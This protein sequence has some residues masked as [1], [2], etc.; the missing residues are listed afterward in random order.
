SPGVVGVDVE[1]RIAFETRR[2]Q[3]VARNSRNQDASTLSALLATNGVLDA[4][5]WSN[6]TAAT[7]NQGATNFP[8]VAHSIYICVYGGT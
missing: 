1:S 2:K 6:R 3:S 4:Y 5:V 8:V 7:V